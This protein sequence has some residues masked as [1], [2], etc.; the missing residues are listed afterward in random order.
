MK[1]EI[2]LTLAISS[3]LVKKWFLNMQIICSKILY[4]MIYIN[5]LNTS[6]EVSIP[7]LLEARQLLCYLSL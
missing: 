3:R 6:K 2:T 5:N 7:F 4:Q 1:T